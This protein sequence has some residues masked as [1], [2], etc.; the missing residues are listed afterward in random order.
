MSLKGLYFV[1]YGLLEEN[2]TIFAIFHNRRSFYS[3]SYFSS[4]KDPDAIKIVSHILKSLFYWKH[5]KFLNS[6]KRQSH[7]W[8]TCLYC[9]VITDSKLTEKRFIFINISQNLYIK[10]VIFLWKIQ[11]QY[12]SRVQAKFQQKLINL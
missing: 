6:D 9:P 7:T 11:V 12:I 10:L 3:T 2:A 1:A 8:H 5:V 4:E